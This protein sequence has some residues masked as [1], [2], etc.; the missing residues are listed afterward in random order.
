MEEH[1]HGLCHTFS[2]SS[3]HTVLP[4]TGYDEAEREV[5]LDGRAS[6]LETDFEGLHCAAR[7]KLDVD[8]EDS[9]VVVL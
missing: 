7:C 2:L 8:V 9:C 1:G 5:C 6:T 3:P 4:P